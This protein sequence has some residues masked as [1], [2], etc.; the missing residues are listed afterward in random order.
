MKEDEPNQQQK[1]NYFRKQLTRKR[2]ANIIEISLDE[3]TFQLTCA[4]EK[5]IMKNL[6]VILARRKTRKQNLFHG[7]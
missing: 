5:G 2:V 1:G 3:K 7:K 6:L 4:N